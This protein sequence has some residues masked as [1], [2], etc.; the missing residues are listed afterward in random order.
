MRLPARVGHEQVGL[1]VAVVVAGRDAHAGVLVVHALRLA[2]LD[3]V[4]VEAVLR[5]RPRDVD[6]EAVRILVVRDVEIGTAVAVDVGEHGAQ[7]VLE[8]RSLEARLDADLAE[9]R[10]PVRAVALVQEEQ[11][12]HS[13]VIRREPGNRV[14]DR[15][16]RVGVAGDEE[17]G[18]PVAIHVR[19]RRARMPAGRSD[20][21]RP[22]ALGER[23]VAVVP[24]QLVVD[25]RRDVEIGEAV[26]VEV[27]GDAAVAADREVGAAICD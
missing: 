27:G 2:A 21:G 15:Q 19:D 10:T 11:V 13:D 9:L 16:V 12:A 7:A 25:R 22:R 20:A 14:L 17:V 24:E 1:P 23:A 8:V 3:E 18:P 4:E 6:V 26:A 5:P